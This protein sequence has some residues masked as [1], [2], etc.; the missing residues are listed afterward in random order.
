MPDPTPSGATPAGNATPAP[1]QGTTPPT[2]PAVKPS[3]ATPPAGAP[4]T[5]PAASPAPAQT[6]APQTVPISALMEEREKRQSLQARLEAL[7]TRLGGQPQPQPA[8]MT[9]QPSQ[10]QQAQEQY[11]QQIEQLWES[12]PRKAVAAEIM[13]ALSWYDNVNASVDAQEAAVGAKYGDFGNYRN[14]VRQYIRSLPHQERARPGVVE[15]AYYAVRGQKFDDV[16]KTEKERLEREYMEKLQRGELGAA[17]PAGG[18]SAPP[19]YQG[20]VTL[21]ED[22]KKAAMAMGIPETEYVK[23]LNLKGA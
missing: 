7:E 19:N 9:P 23:H 20:Q 5:P 12:D 3:G 10:Q 8:Q 2:P 14:E 22:Q 15:F 13:A 17:L 4:A 11:R 21:T 1:G 18:I 6:G 16:L